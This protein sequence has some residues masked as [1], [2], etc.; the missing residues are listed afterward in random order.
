M[1]DGANV[2]YSERFKLLFPVPRGFQL[3]WLRGSD[4]Y[5]HVDAFTNLYGDHNRNVNIGAA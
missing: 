5:V 4:A 3:Q 2:F 1:R